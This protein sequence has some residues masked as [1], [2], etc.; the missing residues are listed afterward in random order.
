[1]KVIKILLITIIFVFLFI[2][3]V[4]FFRNSNSFVAQIAD[5]GENKLK[6]IKKY[7]EKELQ[8][9]VNEI[10]NSLPIIKEAGY[11][12]NQIDIDLGVPSRI[13]IYFEMREKKFYKSWRFKISN[14]FNK[15]RNSNFC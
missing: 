13:N 9:I 10:N 5:Y 2:Y 3:L 14:N 4:I 12:V 8:D 15:F 6:K 1:M 11:S 7:S